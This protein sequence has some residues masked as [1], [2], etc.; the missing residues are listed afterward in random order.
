MRIAGALAE[1]DIERP[2]D[3]RG[4]RV[5]DAD[6]I[7]IVGVLP[8]RQQQQQSRHREGDPDEIE[9]APRRSDGHGQRP[10]ELDRNRQPER[11]RP[12]R[13]VEHQ[14][15]RAQRRA[16]QRNGAR[17]GPLQRPPPRPPRHQQDQ[18]G[19]PDPQRGGPLRADRIE[20]ALGKRRADA[21]RGHRSHQ[22]EHGEQGGAVLGRCGGHDFLLFNS[23]GEPRAGT[24]PARNRKAASV[25]EGGVRGTP[26]DG[27]SL[28]A[29]NDA[30]PLPGQFTWGHGYCASA[31]PA[32]PG[33]VS[34]FC[35]ICLALRIP[36]RLSAASANCSTTS[37]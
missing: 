32:G 7:E 25:V 14:I 2:T 15:G 17:I 12:Q 36:R 35:S 23:A 10:R 5:A 21:Q 24:M 20:Q 22:G 30:D 8:Q 1:D 19:K 26:R 3:P 27:W 4:E 11:H 13:H 28:V 9:R 33:C 29:R 16:V 34:P 37:A 6:G 18:R 31:L